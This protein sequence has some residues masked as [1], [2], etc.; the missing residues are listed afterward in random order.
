ML[1]EAKKRH[2]KGLTPFKLFEMD[3][4]LNSKKKYEIIT[5]CCVVHHINPLEW[6]NTVA[7][8]SKK[9]SKGGVL[10]IL[11]HNPLNPITC[12]VVSKTDIDINAI[13]IKHRNAE[14][15]MDKTGLKNIKSKSF[16]FVPPGNGIADLVDK[17]FGWTMLGGQY[18]T[19]GYKS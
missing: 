12:W 8:L 14:R 5:I 1:E 17:M 4:F 11:E 3:E 16:M 19:I 7:S 2:I 9:L 10:V 6:E 15:L 13:L 18:Y